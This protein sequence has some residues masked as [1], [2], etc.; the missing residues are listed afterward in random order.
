MCFQGVWFTSNAATGPWSVATSVPDE[1]YKIPPS[2]PG[3]NV[4]YVTVEKDN[5]E[6]DDW[7]TYAAVAGYTGMMIGWGCCVWGSGWYY[8]PYLWYGG[9]YPGYIWYAPTYGFAAWYNAY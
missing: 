6:D 3:Y 7:V 2:S 8:Q 5:D 9:F 1:I 4:T